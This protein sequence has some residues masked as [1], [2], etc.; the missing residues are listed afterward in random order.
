MMRFHKACH[1]FSLS[2]LCHLSP[3]SPSPSASLLL[4]PKL[5]GFSTLRARRCARVRRFSGNP[6]ATAMSSRSASR[7]HCL[8]SV[9]PGGAEDGGGSSNGSLSASA[10]ATE[11]DG[12][13]SFSADSLQLPLDFVG[14]GM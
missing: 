13:S 2:P 5:S 6:L 1:R 4:P 7:L 14:C 3:P 9:C 12:N 10:A 8:A 11:D